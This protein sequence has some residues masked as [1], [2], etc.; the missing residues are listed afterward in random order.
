M[1][2]SLC[3]LFFLPSFIITDEWH[4]F[5]VFRREKIQKLAVF[6]SKVI[7]KHTFELFLLCLLAPG[8][9]YIKF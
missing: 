4:C 9:L 1:G 3:S 6:V 7:L 5:A 8:I 2:N